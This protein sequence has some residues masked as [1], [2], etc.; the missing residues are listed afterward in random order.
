MNI[1]SFRELEAYQTAFA[2]QQKVFHASKAW[3]RE[4]VYSLTDQVRRA[5]RSIGANLA[6]AWGKRKYPAHFLSK[7]T[8][9][10]GELQETLHWLDTALACGYLGTADHATFMREAESVGRLLG[11]MMAKHES[12]CVH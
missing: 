3:P 11:G 12:F 7:L 4:E 8:D 10:D 1:R 5:S 9:A 6:E 2:L